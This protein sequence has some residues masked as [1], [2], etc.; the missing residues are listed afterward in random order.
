MPELTR[1]GPVFLLGSPRLRYIQQALTGC[2]RQAA[3]V[4]PQRAGIV[5]RTSPSVGS[6]FW[7]L[8]QLVS[9][10]EPRSRGTGQPRTQRGE[11]SPTGI[12][13]QHPSS[14]ISVIRNEVKDLSV[15]L[16]ICKH[17]VGVCPAHFAPLAPR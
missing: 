12:V 8:T 14:F 6:A 2:P 11:E 4:C 17:L 13:S 10:T 5:L 1:P 16:H 15:R 7:Q 3:S 9:R